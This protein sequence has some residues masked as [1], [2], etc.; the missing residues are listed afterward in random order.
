MV[1]FMLYLLYFSK[2]CFFKKFN[3]FKSKYFSVSFFLGDYVM[4]F[5]FS[6]ISY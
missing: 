6:D 1:N 5:Y 4:I 3:I 2:D